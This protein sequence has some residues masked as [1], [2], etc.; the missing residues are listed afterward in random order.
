MDESLNGYNIS[1]YSDEELRR[2]AR[3]LERKID[4]NLDLITPNEDVDRNIIF[5]TENNLNEVN[6]ID[7]FH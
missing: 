5:T 3:F 1:S 6:M 7:L 2:K 4:E